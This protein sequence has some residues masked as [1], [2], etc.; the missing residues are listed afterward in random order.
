[1]INLIIKKVRNRQF[2]RSRGIT[3][4][5]LQ[6]LD[7]YWDPEMAKILDT[8]GEGNVW[9]EIQLLLANC[10]GKV[11]DIACGTG[12]TMKILRQYP[13]L[14]VHGFDISDLL[15]KT[16]VSKHG[17]LAE[18][19]R[20]MDATKM[21]YGDLSFDYS[22]SIG[23]LEHFTEP[24]IESMLSEAARVTRRTSFHMIPVSRSGR[25]EGWMKTKQSFFNNSTQW[26][27]YK[28]SKSFRKAYPLTSRW[29]DDISVGVWL[30]YEKN[31]PQH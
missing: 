1:M 29:N 3:R 2:G 9:D 14:E 18:R 5:D 31:E 8:W 21:D 11:L 13:K 26:W 7:L 6:D 15:L 27:L 19:L 28:C 24:G 23:S 17:I 22:Y 20:T 10:E 4:S 25:N 30:K 12:N 16:A